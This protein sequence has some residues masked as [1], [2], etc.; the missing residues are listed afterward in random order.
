MM[1][2]KMLSKQREMLATLQETQVN[3]L[4]LIQQ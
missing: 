2:E 3:Q 4:K 1:A